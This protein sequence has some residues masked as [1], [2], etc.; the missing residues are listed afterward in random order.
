MGCVL[1]C[2]ASLH[3]LTPTDSS[4]ALC[5]VFVISAFT[6][7]VKSNSYSTDLIISAAEHLLDALRPPATS[8]GEPSVKDSSAA[9]GFH[10]RIE[11]LLIAAA[12]KMCM[13]SGCSAPPAG[14]SAALL[15][16]FLALQAPVLAPRDTAL[17]EVVATQVVESP[18]PYL[19]SQDLTHA[20]KLPDEST[21]SSIEYMEVTFDSR[22]RTESNCDYV[23]FWQDGTRQGLQKYHGRDPGVWAGVGATEVLRVK[24]SSME[25]RFHSDG[26][27]NDWGYKFTVSFFAKPSVCV[28][29]FYKVISP[30]MSC[31]PLVFFIQHGLHLEQ[32]PPD[33]LCKLFA[34]YLK[35]LT[36]HSDLSF[37]PIFREKQPHATADFFNVLL[38]MKS[39]GHCSAVVVH[40]LFS[41]LY[42]LACASKQQLYL[43]PPDAEKDMICEIGSVL[44]DHLNDS[45]LRAMVEKTFTSESAISSSSSASS[46]VFFAIL[47]SAIDCSSSS[48][49]LES[50]SKNAVPPCSNSHA[51]TLCSSIPLAMIQTSRGWTCS[52][53]NRSIPLF[54]TGVWYCE[55]CQ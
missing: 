27:N 17:F 2:A 29:P 49:I 31:L 55:T 23:S 16:A 6:A 48:A 22:C 11:R 50:A 1:Y 39:L 13:R 46:R 45:A 36:A 53:C 15:R 32:P 24:G 52:Q 3:S 47:A 7:H 12:R 38:L 10:Q 34:M 21:L 42:L 14:V 33:P 25:A 40:S 54:Q 20:I 26:S 35:T 28:V 43:P 9:I 44:A 5:F 37:E 18:H 8:P 30:V 41:K 4:R 51:M 19:D